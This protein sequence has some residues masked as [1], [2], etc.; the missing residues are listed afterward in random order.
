M[1]ASNALDAHKYLVSV[2]EDHCYGK[3]TKLAAILQLPLI[4]F[5]SC[6]WRSPGIH[7]YHREAAAHQDYVENV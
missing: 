4:M 5:S 2:V 7:D 3:S 1:I 6:A